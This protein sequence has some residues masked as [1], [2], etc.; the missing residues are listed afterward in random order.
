MLASLSTFQ[1]ILASIVWIAIS[2][3]FIKWFHKI[4]HKRATKLTTGHWLQY[5]VF[6]III[7]SL[8]IP[9][10]GGFKF[11]PINQSNVYFCN[12]MFANHASVNFAWNFFDAII[13][14]TEGKNPYEKFNTT[15]T[16]RNP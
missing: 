6:L 3:T 8:I 4:I 12:N 2:F 16:K 14:K 5:P 9:I 10:R 13:Y 7:A 1:I 15:L 11:I